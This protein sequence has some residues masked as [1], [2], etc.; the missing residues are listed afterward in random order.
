MKLK[1]ILA[2][3]ALM[4]GS[5][6]VCFLVFEFIIFKYILKTSDAIP[7][8]S[9]NNIIR[10]VPN[11]QATL[12]ERDG[13]SHT[14]SINANGWNSSHDKYIKEKPKHTLRIAVVGDSYV[15]ASAVNVQ[16]GFAEVIEQDLNAK[17]QNSQ[18][19]RFGIDGAPLSQYL[20]MARNEAMQYKPN[21]MVVQL[22]HNDFDESYRFLY[23]RYSSSF[24]KLKLGENTIEE[25]APAPYQPG[26]IDTLKKSRTFRYLYYQTGLSVIIRRIINTKDDEDKTKQ[27]APKH[28]FVQSAIDVRNITELDKIRTVTSYNFKKL[29][30][31]S[32]THNFK[33][34]LVMDPVREAIYQGNDAKNYE[35]NAL[36]QIAKQEA[37]KHNIPFLDLKD[38]MSEHYKINKQRFEFPWDWHWNKLGNKIAGQAIAKK[39]HEQFL[40]RQQ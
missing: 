16:E 37:E 30:D 3:I 32:Q 40:T 39:I 36:N 15:Q 38:A 2:N 13:S 21:I 26:L 9:I 8:T 34:L 33:L 10:Y 23:G 7:N 29:K 12:Y 14:V 11:S 28:G 17:G 35:A 25:V 4:A 24:M 1:S 31:L 19:Y 27:Q 20:Y 5:L 18:I 22:I 6:L